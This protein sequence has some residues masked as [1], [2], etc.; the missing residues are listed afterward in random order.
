M[1]ITYKTSKDYYH[2][3]VDAVIEGEQFR[4][5]FIQYFMHAE[6]K[7]GHK[8]FEWVDYILDKYLLYSRT[9]FTKMESQIGGMMDGLELI[10]DKE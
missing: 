3:V 4:Y 9:G 7:V 8:K 5:L 2:E 10:L 1:I 6:D